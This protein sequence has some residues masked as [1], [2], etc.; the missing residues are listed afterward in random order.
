M[1]TIDLA[2]KNH[3]YVI[4]MRREFHMN[5]EVSMQEYNTCKRIK[6]ELEKM[7]VEYK[8]I[9]GTGV[10]ATIKG[11]KPGK[12]VALRGD[13]D[14]LAVVEENTHD[15]VSKV[16]GMM[17]ACG[18]DTHGAMLLGAV[19][20]LN[21]MK[22]EIE[23]TV[24]FFFQPGE[25]VGKGAAAMVAEGAL[26]G[27]DGVMGIHIS[28]DMPTGTIN[29]DP[30]P[31]MAS[32]DSFKVTIT[33]KGGHGARPEQCIDA[34][35][36]G[37]AT[38][39]NLQSIVSRELSPFDPVVVTT[40]SIKSGTRFNVIAPTAV[41]EGT[42]R[43][44]KTEYKQIIADAIER[45]A[46]ST[47]EA[48]RATAEMEYSSLVKPTINDDACA[49]LA[50]E[51]AAKIV[52]KENV[53]HTPAGTGGEDFSEF[54]SIVPGVM[55]RLGAGNTEKGTTYPHHHG[56]FDVDEDAFVYGVAF[57]AQYAIDYLK[58]NPKTL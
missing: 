35:V 46:K 48:Y 40:G 42:V 22:D 11:T 7:G 25:E 45:I 37:A 14:A 28:S 51:S 21:E 3:D 53:I 58:K 5:P 39:M 55:T 15:Y 31:R 33:G 10:I 8:G 27:V 16:H 29:A 30:G 20:V 49:E 47:A 17:H 9:A 52:G 1:K 50:Q 41:L 24:K 34:V 54:S 57:Y 18:H 12:T 23:G 6:E 26:E 2:K 4:Q 19:K 44:Y 32:A 36:V 56:K 38:V 43:Y 13:I